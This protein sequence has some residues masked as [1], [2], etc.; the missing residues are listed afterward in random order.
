MTIEAGKAPKGLGFFALPMPIWLGHILASLFLHQDLVFLHYQEKILARHQQQDWLDAVYTANPQD[1]MVI[2]FHQWFKT[3]AG[4]NIPWDSGCNA[5]LQNLELDKQQLFD[6]WTTHT[7]DCA[8]CQ[9]ALTKINRLTVLSYV[10]ALV[11]L[12]L[13][14]VIDAR[15]VAF[16]MATTTDLMN[17]SPLTVIPPTGFWIAI[18]GAII[19][20][21]IG[22]LL[23]KLS[24]LFHV[25][26]FE[27]SQNN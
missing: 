21:T 27:H 16:K 23:K 26:E 20:A 25:Y 18:A 5:Q 19:L 22:Y 10:G 12:L 15:T 6:V 8:V 14:I 1:K 4:G 7:K 17:I 13:G 3:R 2:T 9:N 11:C 24:R